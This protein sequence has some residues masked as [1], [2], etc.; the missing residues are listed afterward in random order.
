IMG[1]HDRDKERL[2][3]FF[4]E[5]YD[6]YKVIEVGGK[7]VL[8]SHY[9]AKDPLTERYPERQELVREIYFSEGCELLL[10]GHVHWNREGVRCACH[11]LGVR[12]I[13]VN[14]EWHRYAPVSEEK[15]LEKLNL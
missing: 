10:H 3:D 7:R 11:K 1:N 2:S 6:F 4:D 13:N 5:V 14:T 9:P 8:L 12:C 15:V